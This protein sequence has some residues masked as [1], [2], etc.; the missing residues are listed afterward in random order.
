MP[1]SRTAGILYDKYNVTR[2]QDKGVHA[3]FTTIIAVSAGGG[4][5][6]D[7]CPGRTRGGLCDN[8]DP[9]VSRKSYLAFINFQA[10]L[11]SSVAR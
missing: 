7:F 8:C 2:H 4:G 1:E 11:I 9:R 3:S 10:E 5:E 6:K